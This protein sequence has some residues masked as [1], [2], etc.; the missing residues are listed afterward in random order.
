MSEQPSEIEHEVRDYVRSEVN[1]GFGTRD[2]I[3][4]NVSEYFEDDFPDLDPFL[5]AH[6][7]DEELTRHHKEQANWDG[8]TDCDRL[9][10][11][12]AQLERQGIVARQDFACCGNCGV[13]EI[14]AEATPETSRGYVFYHMQDTQRA[15]DGGDL[16]FN[17]G[18]F[19]G[20]EADTVAIGWRLFESLRD[21]GLKPKWDGDIRQRVSLPMTWHKRRALEE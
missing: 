7:V 19:H 21:A 3:V 15:V 4:T 18:V 20:G 2:E 1:S 10:H 14:S 9:D 13:A 12:F 16:S 8:P 6:V 17:Y 11:A 5:V